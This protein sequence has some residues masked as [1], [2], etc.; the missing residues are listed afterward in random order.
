[1]LETTNTVLILR[2]FSLFKI[3]SGNEISRAANFAALCVSTP[4]EIC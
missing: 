3:F 1:M 2:L 4:G